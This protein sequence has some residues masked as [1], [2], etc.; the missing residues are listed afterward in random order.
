ML[1]QYIY[2]EQVLKLLGKI[3]TN[4]TLAQTGDVAHNIMYIY[5]YFILLVPYRIAP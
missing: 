2:T 4:P 1:S 3:L 5:L